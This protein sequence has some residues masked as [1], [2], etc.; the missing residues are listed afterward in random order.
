MRW[1]VLLSCLFLT[2]SAAAAQAPAPAAPA[3]EPFAPL[4]FLVG[5]WVTDDGS[6]HFEVTEEVQKNVLVRR[7]HSDSPAANGRPA[8]VHDDLMVI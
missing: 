3:G 4:R 6:G 2:A 8:S 5:D 1:T 7:N